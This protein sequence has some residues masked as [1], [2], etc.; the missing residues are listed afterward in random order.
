M[1]E[2]RCNA[3]IL[4]KTWKNA[5]TVKQPYGEAYQKQK[6]LSGFSNSKSVAKALRIP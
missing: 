4:H 1:M 2:K 5:Y 3:S 6:F